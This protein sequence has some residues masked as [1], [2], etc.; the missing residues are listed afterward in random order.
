MKLVVQSRAFALIDGSLLD[1]VTRE[2]VMRLPKGTGSDPSMLERFVHQI[3]CRVEKH[4][5][6]LHEHIESYYV[7]PDNHLPD[8]EQEQVER[9][10]TVVIP[11]HHLN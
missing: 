3:A 4:T 5:S 10:G 2:Y 7:I 11:A 8:S 6:S 1:F 9:H